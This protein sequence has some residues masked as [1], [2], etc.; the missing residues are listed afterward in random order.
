MH[1]PQASC[2]ST[3]VVCTLVPG[4][5][6]ETLVVVAPAVGIRVYTQTSTHNHHHHRGRRAAP[7]EVIARDFICLLFFRKRRQSRLLG[8][9]VC[10]LGCTCNFVVANTFRAVDS[11]RALIGGASNMHLHCA[12]LPA[13]DSI[14]CDPVDTAHPAPHPRYRNCGISP[15]SPQ[16]HTAHPGPGPERRGTTQPGNRAIAA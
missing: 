15:A 8:P 1:Q 3:A 9:H 14:G 2:G 10:P 11:L 12:E 7:S 13:R 5:P 16:P 4:N 6:L